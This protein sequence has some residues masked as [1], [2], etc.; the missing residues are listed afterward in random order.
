MEISLVSD[1]EEHRNNTDVVTLM[2][3]H[4]AKG[5]EFDNVF[6]VGLEEGLFPHVNSMDYTDDLEE[7]RRLCYV[8]V[9]RAKKRLILVNAKRRLL[10]GKVSVN[11]PSRFISE[12]D[13]KYLDS[14]E[15]EEA[16]K[17]NRKDMI[18]DSISYNV[19]DKVVHEKYGEGIIV[20]T[21]SILTIAFSQKYGIIKI[22]KGHKSLRKV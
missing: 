16:P 9:T 2:T 14:D 12:I 15:P 20:Q 10:Y 5:L 21:G 1:I 17:I 6:I 22:M 13:D 4:S 7:E 18:D 11:A 3:I 8:A 19:G